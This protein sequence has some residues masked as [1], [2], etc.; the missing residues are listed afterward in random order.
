MT[1]GVSVRRRWY[2]RP[3]LHFVLGGVL[4]FG[5]DRVWMSAPRA[6][7][8][9][10]RAPIV[11]DAGRL[12]ESHRQTLGRLP[13][14]EELDGLL[15][16]EIENELLYQGALARNFDKG[17]RAVRAWLVRKMRFVSDDPERSDE[18]LYEEALALGLDR[19]DQ[20]LRRSM[21]EKMRL[22][23]DLVAPPHEPTDEELQRYLDDHADRFRD[24][25]R[26][27]LDHVFYSRDRRG[28]STAH[29]ASTALESIRSPPAQPWR[30]QGDPFPLGRSFQ[31]RSERQLESLF[32]TKFAQKVFSLAGDGWQGRIPSAYG[33]HLV[34]V[35]ERRES[36]VPP[37][38]NLRNQLRY[39]LLAE[40]REEV[41]DQFVAQ[42]RGQH[43]IFIEFPDGRGRM[44]ASDA[45]AN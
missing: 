21:V 19:E 38:A 41:L 31:V 32:G 5:V 45:L 27:S 8:P 17:D 22:M 20:V 37:L 42:L 25:A 18:E 14:K 7:D 40:R 24:P 15:R 35:T 26:L 1:E 34:R 10:S 2:Q 44:R 6:T 36:H 16:N 9:V 11:I 30:D 28:I 4:L 29:D 43:E 3:L 12:A 39:R 33:E 23:A 13:S